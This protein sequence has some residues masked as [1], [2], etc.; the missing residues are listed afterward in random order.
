MNI[1][2]LTRGLVLLK[3]YTK[4]CAPAATWN[5]LKQTYYKCF[6][7]C[8]EDPQKKNKIYYIVYQEN[9]RANFQKN[10]YGDFINVFLQGK[11]FKD[12]IFYPSL[13]EWDTPLF[14][15][16][17]Q[18]FRELSMRGYLIFFLTPNPAA[19]KT[20]PIRQINN[21][22]FV[23]K[24]ID[25]M[26]ALRE[27]PLIL[28]IS[29]TP[30]IVCKEL[31]SN[32]RLIYDYMDELDV[33]GSYCELMENDHKRLIDTSD[34]V[35]ATSENLYSGVK[36]MR[37]DAILTPNGVRIEDFKVEVERIPSDLEPIIKRN[38]PIVGY[39]G[40]LA[41]WLDYDL[42]NF[43]CDNCEELSFVFIGPK[44]DNSSGKLRAFNNLFLLGSKKY[45]DLKHYLKCFD[46]AIIPFQTGKVADST[47][48]VKLFEYM[49]GGKPI[50]TTGMKE[51][52]KFKGV[53]VS[54]S[55]RDFIGNLRKSLT[56]KNHNEYLTLLKEEATTNTW[57]ERVHKIVA[58]LDNTAKSRR[59]TSKDGG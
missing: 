51:C 29:W 43:A 52:R 54:E 13:V 53:F 10:R 34:V 46:V 50:V 41:K 15:R 42:I 35:M 11:N 21:N 5:M 48:P 7:G 33:F 30:H 12:I 23:I 17:H 22:L 6:T 47:S 2:R 57:Q 31:F 26:F 18:L 55:Y 49:A 59:C 32:S 20:N 58:A 44:L 3:I 16:P 28:W 24:D 37:H 45:E 40:A 25:M 56:M 39:Y 4:K 38:K 27:E 14:Q 1:N 8:S 19:D 9:L 36:K